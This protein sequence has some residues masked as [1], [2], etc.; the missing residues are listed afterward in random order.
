MILERRV[1]NFRAAVEHAGTALISLTT[2]LPAGDLVNL[3]RA[4]FSQDGPEPL[5]TLARSVERDLAAEIEQEH[6]GSAAIVPVVATLEE[7]IRLYA[8]PLDVVIEHHSLQEA[9]VAASILKKG[10]VLLVGLSGHEKALLLALL[11]ALYRGYLTQK[12]LLFDLALPSLKLLLGRTGA[13]ADAILRLEQEVERL[14]RLDP[15]RR[16]FTIPAPV[17]DF[18]GYQKELA[19]V[20]AALSGSGAAAISAV[21]GMGGVGKSELARKAAQ[22][23]VA[24]FPDGQILVDMLGT[25]QPRSA[26]EAM[27]DVLL[28]LGAETVDPRTRD[29]DY[30]N[31]LEGKRALILLDNVASGTGLDGLRPPSPAALLVTSRTRIALAGV[32]PIE[33]E[34]LTRDAAKA[35]LGEIVPALDEASR[36]GLADLC[37]GLPLALRV[38]GAYLQETGALPAAYIDALKQRRLDHLARSAGDIER[39]E[40][41][42]RVVLG[43]SYDRL[44]ESDPDLARSFTLL[45]VFPADFNAEGAAAVLDLA[46]EEAER[47]L[48][49][50]YRRSLV[51]R[52]SDGRY[53]LHDLLR[54]VAA[55]RCDRDDV[56]AA[57]KRHQEHYLNLLEWCEQEYFVRRVEVRRALAAFEIEHANI[58]GAVQHSA[59]SDDATSAAA[60]QARVGILASSLGRREEALTATEE[61]VDLNRR[62][63]AERPD[64][65]LPDLAGSLSN[66]G[67]SLDALGR[68]EEALAAAEE[69]VSIHRQLAADNPDTFLPDLAGSLNNLGNRLRVLGR[70]EEAVAAT[71]VAVT[72]SRHLSAHQADAILPDLATSLN[73]WGSDLNAVGRHEEALAATEEAVAIRRRLAEEWPDAFLNNLATSLAVR[74]NCLDGLGRVEEALASTGDAIAAL[75]PDFLQHPPAVMHWMVPMLQ[76]YLKRCGRLGVEPDGELLGPIIDVLRRLEPHD[77]GP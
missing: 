66:L 6:G 67:N 53:R 61:A 48:G 47:R 4:L 30:R 73:N 22:E 8:P 26:A 19:D 72:I 25:T 43:L 77:G 2:G 69:A 42:P 49:L 60:G 20:R 58:I 3:G 46:P 17:G 51:Q 38:A 11:K 9:S 36:D 65:F 32:Q 37:C 10:E 16:P 62:L 15:P 41:D 64:A 54:E 39:P 56:A 74:A 34:Q 52:P 28:A 29:A 35:L 24:A 1:A 63:A 71:E 13:N 70:C 33:L 55:D 76:L 27:T 7:L 40:L 31:R 68:R 75:R 14:K 44:A 59:G 45:A 18:K 21:H 12:A 5:Q 50:L 23:M 57:A